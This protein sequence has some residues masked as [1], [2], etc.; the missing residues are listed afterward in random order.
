MTMVTSLYRTFTRMA[1]VWA[2]LALANVAQVC[3]AD[4]DTTRIL[5]IGNSYI[6]SNNLPGMVAQLA[7][8]LGEEVET[9]MVVP[10]GST[11][12]LLQPT[13]TKARRLSPTSSGDTR[14]W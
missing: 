6:N 12:E 10:G 8:S 11:F 4:A 7:A 1:S 9:M 2:M 5:F 3:R 13:M 14:A